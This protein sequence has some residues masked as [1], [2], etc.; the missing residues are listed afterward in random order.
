MQEGP[1]YI[2]P[3]VMQLADGTTMVKP[4]RAIQR[5]RA[6]R[7]AAMTGVSR[8][9]LSALADCGLIRRCQPSPEGTCYYPAEVEAF[10]LRTETEPDFWNTVRTRAYLRGETLKESKT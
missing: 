10:I 2:P 8:K 5:A 3:V 6:S 9:V 7:V 1:W 4:G